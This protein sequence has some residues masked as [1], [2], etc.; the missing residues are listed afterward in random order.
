MQRAVAV[1]DLGYGDAGKG[2]IV[3]FLVRRESAKWVVRFNGGPQAAHN[4]VLDDNTHHT[5]STWGSGTFAGANTYLQRQ[6]F[7]DPVAAHAESVAL[8]SAGVSRP[9]SRLFIEGNCGVITPWHVAEN[10][11]DERL[12][13]KVRH[14]SCGAGFG[15]ARFDQLHRTQ[16]YMEL[17]AFLNGRAKALDAFKWIMDYKAGVLRRRRPECEDTHEWK[18]FFDVSD[19]QIHTWFEHCVG[20]AELCVI[21]EDEDFPID[22]GDVVIGE[23]AQGVMIDEKH[24]APKHRTWSNCTFEN[25]MWSEE[26]VRLG[27]HRTYAVRHG[28]GPLPWE[29][30]D[31]APDLHNGVNEW[32]G[33][34]RMGLLD[35]DVLRGAVAYCGRV[36]ELAVTWVDHWSKSPRMWASNGRLHR[37][38]GRGQRTHHDPLELFQRELGVPVTIASYG[39]KPSQKYDRA[40]VPVVSPVTTAGL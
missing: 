38:T 37:I 32:Q 17:G 27:V 16:G 12:R 9:Y 4:V 28:P 26:C 1:V 18:Q 30:D 29:F 40:D 31:A 8:I 24:G 36:D 19:Q 39:P 22:I 20:M 14:G 34:V 21:D 25:F 23:G 10:R 35:F 2:S 3:D 13:G 7:V 11:I 6:V 33:M 5:F 15:A